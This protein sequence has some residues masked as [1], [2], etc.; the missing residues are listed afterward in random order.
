MATSGRGIGVG[1]YNVQGAVDI[2]HHLIRN[3]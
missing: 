1:G 3:A 2:E